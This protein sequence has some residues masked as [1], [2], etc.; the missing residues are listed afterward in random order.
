MVERLYHTEEVAAF[1]SCSAYQSLLAAHVL[2]GWLA[3][4]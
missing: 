2:V 1:N 4:S 3:A